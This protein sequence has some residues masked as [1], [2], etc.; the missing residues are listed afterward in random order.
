MLDAVAMGRGWVRLELSRSTRDPTRLRV[1]LV[2][3]QQFADPA[4]KANRRE[5]AGTAA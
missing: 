1:V 2:T 3:K 5:M 4:A